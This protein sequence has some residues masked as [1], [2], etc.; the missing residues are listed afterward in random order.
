MT[1]P[2]NKFGGLAQQLVDAGLVTEAHMHSAQTEAQQQKR[3]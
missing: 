1:T 2:T 3:D